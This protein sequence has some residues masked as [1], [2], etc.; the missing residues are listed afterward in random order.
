MVFRSK[1][2]LLQVEHVA[3]LELIRG[4]AALLALPNQV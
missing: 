2:V 4:L 1:K 3:F